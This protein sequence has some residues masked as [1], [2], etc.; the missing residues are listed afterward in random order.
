MER[1]EISSGFWLE[2]DRT[3]PPDGLPV[4]FIHGGYGG[5]ITTLFG[6]PRWFDGVFLPSDPVRLVRYSRRNSGASSYVFEPFDL[7]DLAADAAGLLDALAIDRAVIVGSSAGGPV[8]LEFA[9]AWPE[10]VIALALPN[11]GP[12]I[13]CERPSLLPDPV[14]ESILA[15]LYEVAGRLAIVRDVDHRGVETAFA[16]RADQ[17]RA[18][19]LDEAVL[20]APRLGRDPAELLALAAGVS[21]DDLRWQWHGSVLNWAATEGHDHAPRLSEI[22]VATCIIHGDADTVVPFEYGQ[23]LH[24][25]IAGS[26]FHRIAAGPHEITR[27]PRGATILRRWA[28]GIAEQVAGSRVNKMSRGTDAPDT[29]LS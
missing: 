2:T 21:D 5:P 7:L 4:L 13:M 27:D 24:R 29:T 17:I 16:S 25:G 26:S 20:R 14:P 1:I 23:M 18:A 6:P 9:L 10:R 3:G 22:D 11:T 28:L 19:L 15:R 12:A 8:A